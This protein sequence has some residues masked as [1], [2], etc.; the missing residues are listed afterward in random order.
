MASKACIPGRED[1]SVRS[2]R[3]RDDFKIARTPASTMLS[4]RMTTQASPCPDPCEACGGDFEL[5]A[6]GRWVH[7]CN[8]TPRF[9]RREP[10]MRPPIL[11]HY[12]RM[13]H[14]E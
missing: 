12:D 1:F 9:L 6:A 7:S 13:E 10:A 2:Q 14:D 3:R 5:D 4:G 11:D 8:P